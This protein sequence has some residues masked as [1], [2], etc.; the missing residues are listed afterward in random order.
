LKKLKADEKCKGIYLYCKDVDG[1]FA[2]IEEL[3]E[4]T[5]EL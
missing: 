5:I 1:G 4:W 2:S 3:K